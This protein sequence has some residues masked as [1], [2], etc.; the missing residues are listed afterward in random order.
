M[1]VSQYYA[2]YSTIHAYAEY[3]T[4]PPQNIMQNIIIPIKHSYEPE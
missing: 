4:I 3:S 2:E 1:H